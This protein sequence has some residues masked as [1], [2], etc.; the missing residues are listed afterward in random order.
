M[1]H[2]GLEGN[3]ISKQ[4]Y[5]TLLK[6][7]ERLRAQ[8]NEKKKGSDGLRQKY[9]DMKAGATEKYRWFQ[10]TVSEKDSE[11]KKLN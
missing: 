5:L 11:I 8:V 4:V 3:V 2:P 6:E 7:N 9:K 1:P 10:N